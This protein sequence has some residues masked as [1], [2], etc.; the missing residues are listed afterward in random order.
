MSEVA[1]QKRTVSQKMLDGIEKV[2]NKV[3]HPVMIFL[4][5]I[6]II[7]VFSAVF[8]AIG[9]KVTYDVAEPVPMFLRSATSESISDR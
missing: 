6:G 8:A 7:I 1:L 4:I 5:L 3:P 2:G 9:V